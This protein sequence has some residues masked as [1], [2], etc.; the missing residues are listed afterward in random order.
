MALAH[1]LTLWQR[2][3]RGRVHL[4]HSALGGPAAAGLRYTRAARLAL[5]IRTARHLGLTLPPALLERA[6][7]VFPAP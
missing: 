1:A 4:L 2:P 7:P 3:L 5:N 6:G